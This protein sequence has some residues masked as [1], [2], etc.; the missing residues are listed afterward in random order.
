MGR[1]LSL[2]KK[3]RKLL[4]A[5]AAAVLLCGLAGVGRYPGPGIPIFAGAKHD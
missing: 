1:V 4:A 5:A 3:Y 2:L